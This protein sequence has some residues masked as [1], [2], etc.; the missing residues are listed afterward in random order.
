MAIYAPKDGRRKTFLYDKAFGEA[1]TQEQVYEDTQALIR[2][3][4]DGARQY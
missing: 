1:S 2:S 4:L 3:V